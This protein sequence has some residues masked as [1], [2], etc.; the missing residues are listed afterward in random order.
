MVS[1]QHTQP[2][3]ANINFNDINAWLAVLASEYDAADMLRLTHACELIQ[4]VYREKVEVVGKP[5]LQHALGAASILVSINL[6]AETVTAALL[7]ALPSYAPRWKEQLAGHFSYSVIEMVD[8]ISRI[9]QVQQFSEMQNLHQTEMTPEAR[10]QQVEGLRKML[11][12][13]ASDIRVVLIKLAE[14]TQT[15]RY[16]ADAEPLLQQKI[17]QETQSIFAPLANRLGLWQIKWEL[18]DLSMR[19]LEPVLYRQVAKLLDEKRVDREHYIQL[20]ID[21]LQHALDQA[22]LSAEVTGRPKHIYSIINKMKH[23]KLDFSKLYDVRALRILVNDVEECYGALSIVHNIW[24]PMASEY[25][26]YIAQPKGNNY[27]S[28]H[29]V[30]VGPQERTLEVQIRTYQMHYDSELGIAAH[31]R[32]KEKSAS[33]AAYDEKIAWLRQ[34]L[35]WKDDLSQRS[36]LQEQF[37]NSI[38]SDQVYVLTPQGKVIDLPN[39]ATPVDFAYTLHSSLGHR[40]RG[41]K[42][43]GKIVPLNYKLQNAQRVEILTSK[44]ESPSLDW[45][46]PSSGFLSTNRARAKVRAW[47]NQQNIDELIEQGR[48]LFE[49]ELQ[50][51]GCQSVNIEKLAQRL[52][53][54]KPDGLF[55]ALQKG[56]LTTLRLARAIQAEQPNKPLVMPEVTVAIPK[57]PQVLGEHKQANI[58]VGGE[59]NVLTRLAKCCEPHVPQEIVAY[60]TRDRGIAIHRADCHFITELSDMRQDR[61]L[62]ASWKSAEK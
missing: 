27:R 56:A 21:T 3:F 23:K 20:I 46:T 60:I 59:N 7:H 12:A 6:D 50:R 19:Y 36:E 41:A 17:A 40:T 37:K 5:L 8:G 33:D 9:E 13:M 28:L 49:R 45:L 55:V 53:F 26:D 57:E 51:L 31:W 30:V 18:E 35:A 15:M 48:I 32:Y 54:N 38:F 14:R 25:D 22:G 42:V 44:Q 10:H 29:T 39:G 52:H 58:E 1:V 16:L 2:S 43:D 34:V 11:L 62:T 24:Q 4:S 47:F 61:L